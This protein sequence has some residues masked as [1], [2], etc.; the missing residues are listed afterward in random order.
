MVPKHAERLVLAIIK[1][2]NADNKMPSHVSRSRMRT[3]THTPAHHVSQA[4]TMLVSLS[5]LP[6]RHTTGLVT[7]VSA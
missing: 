1:Y 5:T 7:F 2:P 4:Q 6:A 3:T